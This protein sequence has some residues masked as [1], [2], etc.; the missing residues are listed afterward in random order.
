MRLI[1][2]SLRLRLCLTIASGFVALLGGVAVWVTAEVRA[3]VTRDFDAG[4][5]QRARQLAG[6]CEV[7]KDGTIEFD[8]V[9]RFHPEFERE[10]GPDLYQI[11]LPLQRVTYRSTWLDED[12]VATPE[13]RVEPTI[14]D[15]VLAGGRRV[16]VGHAGF[17]VKGPDE[18]PFD[19]GGAVGA[20]APRMILAVA[21]GREELDAL[22]ARA[23]WA[24]LG[25]AGVAVTLALV[26]LWWLVARG[27]RPV[28]AVAAQV[29]AMTPADLGRRVEP[30]WTPRELAPI[31]TQ[32]NAFVRRLHD[33]MERERRF[34]GNV[35]HELRTPVAELRSLAAVATRWPDDKPAILGFFGDVRDIAR[36]MDSVITNLLLL[37]RCHSGR[38]RIERARV[39]VEPLLTAA[40]ERH[41]P[42]AVAAGLEV[43]TRFE[44]GTC[45]D[46]DADKL[47]I[48]LDNLVANAVSYA[49]PGTTV[50]CST[51]RDGD[52]VRITV[53][54]RA[55]PFAAGDLERLSEPFWR[56]DTARAG[57]EHAGL[58]LAL[59]TALAALLGLR[60][61][62]EQDDGGVFRAAVTGAAATAD[63]PAPGAGVPEL[64]RAHPSRGEP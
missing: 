22:L 19:L 61:S 45:L 27:L 50:R 12:L 55:E 16:R 43:A 42:R 63:E 60:V 54:N 56:R 47:A 64:L 59:V 17:V 20:G 36:R 15:L 25:G 11:W 21:R 34:A 49:I 13:F 1:P 2:D 35:A 41:G 14:G 52:R 29:G 62:F 7:E 37:A 57:A 3:H 53:E 39:E 10:Q 51:E 44:D 32:F 24:I 4:I 6:L 33:A 58:G 26:L 9:A 30:G 48:L 46:T 18:A 23:S 31:V 8:Y 5:V 28:A 40:I 38:E